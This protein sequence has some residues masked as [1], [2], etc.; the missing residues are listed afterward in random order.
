[1]ILCA[2]IA[3]NCP[4][5]RPNKRSS[6]KSNALIA[7]IAIK[8][9]VLYNTNFDSNQGV[10]AQVGVLVEVK[11]PASNRLKLGITQFTKDLFHYVAPFSDYEQ[12]LSSRRPLHGPENR[13]GGV[14]FSDR[15]RVRSGLPL[16]A[17]PRPCF[18]KNN[19]FA[20]D[21]P[22]GPS[23]PSKTNAKALVISQGRA[24]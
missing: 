1:V 12:L 22:C 6:D 5:Y 11:K 15:H 8:V 16:E 23:I 24:F 19:G 9:V 3:S 2:D 14:F 21:S 20:P 17:Q 4:R 18:V 10:Q 13:N 7:L